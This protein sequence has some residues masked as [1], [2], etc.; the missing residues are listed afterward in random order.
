MFLVLDALS[1]IRDIRRQGWM[2]DIWGGAL[3][4]P[5]M[6]GGLIF[7]WTFEGAVVLVT[8]TVALVIAGQIH[9]R[10]RFSR[11]IGLCHLPWLVVL[12]WFVHR[13]I[14]TDHSLWLQTWGWYVAATIAIS[15]VFDALDVWRYTRGQKTFAWAS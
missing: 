9:R 8:N 7:I 4:I 3:N 15:L 2:I 6:I 5:Q 10:A 11:L 1:M 12:P 14:G 13:L